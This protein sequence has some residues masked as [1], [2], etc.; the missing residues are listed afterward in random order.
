MELPAAYLL[1]DTVYWKGTMFDRR[2][3][4]MILCLGLAMSGAAPSMAKDR[5]DRSGSDGGSSNSGSGSHDSGGDDGG[6]DD[7]DNSGSSS[8]GRDDNDSGGNSGSGHDDNDNSGSSG[9]DG[10]GGSDDGKSGDDGK[11]SGR[12]RGRDDGDRI[13]QA[14]KN[15]K[16]ASLRK[17]LPAVRKLYPGEVVNIRLTGSGSSLIYRIRV[18]SILNK[19]IEVRVDAFSGVI[20]GAFDV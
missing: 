17:I 9:N 4:L 3:I 13:R 7:H 15:G 19:L 11:G 12:T 6:H 16:A 8:G 10:H 2:Q 14:V 1:C 20:I 5:G 18:I